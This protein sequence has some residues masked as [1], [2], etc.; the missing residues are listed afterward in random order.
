MLGL[1][2]LIDIKKKCDILWTT[3]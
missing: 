3:E 1:T 2:V